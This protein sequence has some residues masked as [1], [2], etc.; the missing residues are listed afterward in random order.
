MFV[1][2]VLIPTTELLGAAEFIF[3]YLLHYTTLHYVTC[4]V[5]HDESGDE[6]CSDQRNKLWY[7][8]V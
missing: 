4:G 3:K 2:G 1:L 7:T 6:T 8:F 5:F